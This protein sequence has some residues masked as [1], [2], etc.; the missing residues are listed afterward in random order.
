MR[1][2]VDMWIAKDVLCL[3]ATKGTLDK[4]FVNENDEGEQTRE[5]FL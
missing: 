3:Y 4:D 2:L 5:R 1:L